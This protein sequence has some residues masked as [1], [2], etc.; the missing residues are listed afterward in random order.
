M[1]CLEWMLDWAELDVDYHITV[2]SLASNYMRKSGCYDNACHLSGVLQQYISRCVVG[3]RVMAAN[4]KQYH[5]DMKIADLDACSWYPSAMYFMSGFL[6]GLPAVFQ[7]KSY[8]VLK[9][10]DGYLIRIKSIKLTK[11]WN[12]PLT[13][14][15]NED[16]VK[17]FTTDMDDE[18]FYIDKVGLED[19]ITF[20]GVEFEII[21][22]YYFYE[23]KNI[24]TR[25]GHKFQILFEAHLLSVV[26]RVRSGVVWE[27]VPSS[28]G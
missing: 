9:A 5:V 24:L 4:N 25:A 12:F 11:H 16:G 1:L 13:S 19:L 23:G 15:I 8:D 27:E 2:M 21:D 20:H 18:I 6:K 3:G 28:W 10:Q 17:D 22:G 26:R 14:T 7:N